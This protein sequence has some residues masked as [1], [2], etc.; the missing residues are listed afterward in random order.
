LKKKI[1]IIIAII[2]II[3]TIIRTLIVGISFLNF[4]NALIENQTTLIKEILE[5]V[6]DKEKFLKIIKNSHHIKNIKFIPLETTSKPIKIDYNIDKKTIIS[7][8]PF[9]KNLTLEIIF[10]GEDYFS[11]LQNAIIQL[12]LIALISLIVIILIVN[13]FLTPYL[14]ILEKVKS[15]TEEIL[16]GNFSTEIDTKLKGE[17]KEFVDSYNDFLRKL[18]D[19][20]GVIEEKYTSLIE[21]EKS[22]NPL[23]DAKETIEQLANIFKF[24]RLIE[25]DLNYEIILERLIE[26]IK[27][28]NINHFGLVGIDNNE[29]EVFYSYIEGEICCDILNF[30]NSCRAYRLK[31]EVDSFKFEHVC[32]MHLCENYHVCIPFSTNGNFTGVVKIMFTEENEKEINHILPY[33]R[34]YLNEVSSIIESKYTLELLHNQNIKDPLTGLFNRRYFEEILT[35]ILANAKRNNTKLGFLMLDMDYFKKVNDTYGHDAGDMLLKELAEV[36]K[37]TIRE[38]DIPIRFGGEEFLILLTNL[39]NKNDLLIAAEKLRKAI[40][41][42]KFDIGEDEISKTVSIGASLF[43]TDCKT[44]WECIKYADIA[45]YEAKNQGRN[46]VVLFDEKLKEKVSYAD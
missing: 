24:K 26:V 30:P 13:Y 3:S 1:L 7:T 31:K 25:E 39:K 35:H 16:K 37:N 41:R 43:P 19:S 17:A 18:R 40:E 11:K 8:I 29:K 44:G 36:I 2:M 5:E 10:S 6:N 20:F 33:L 15:S 21:K 46:K 28:F 9:S 38:S 12:I 34:A 45:L 22:D 42:H 4:S 27:S 23:N 14:E 32:Q